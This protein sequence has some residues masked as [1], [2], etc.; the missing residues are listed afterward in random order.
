MFLMIHVFRASCLFLKRR[1]KVEGVER[2]GGVGEVGGVGIGKG[3]EGRKAGKARR[4]GRVRAFI[5]MYI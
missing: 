4:V 2:A 1:W 5:G 3:G